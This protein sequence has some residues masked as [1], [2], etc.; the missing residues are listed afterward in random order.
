MKFNYFLLL[1]ICLIHSLQVCVFAQA[2]STVNDVL[3]P[4]YQIENVVITATRTPRPL[5]DIPTETNVL[6]EKDLKNS[7]A[8]TVADAIRWIPG[9]SIS[10][11]AAYGSSRRFT[12]LIRG[13][14][15]HYSLVLVDGERVKGEHIHTGINLNLIPVSMVEQIEVIKGPS[16]SLYGSEAMGGIINIISKPI[17]SELFLETEY[18]YSSFNTHNANLSFGHKPGKAGYL[19]SSRM[20]S[21]DGFQGNWYNQSNFLGKFQY[22]INPKNALNINLKHYNINY[23]KGSNVNDNETD[24]I[25]S[26]KTVLPQ[27]SYLKTTLAYSQFNGSR[28]DATNITS[29]FNVQYVL[30][31]N[32]QHQITAGGECRSEDFRRVATPHENETIFNLFIQDE[33]EL[34]RIISSVISVRTDFHENIQPVISPG[35]SVMFK[36]LLSMRIRASVSRG[37]RAPSLQDKYEY[38]FFHKTYYRDGNPELKPEYSTSYSCGVEQDLTPDISCRVSLFQNKFK[39]LIAVVPTGVYEDTLEIHRKE[40]INSA[41]SNGLEFEI[42]YRSGNFYAGTGYSFI[43][44]EDNQESALSYNPAHTIHFR[45]HYFAEQIQLTTML[46]VENARE[47]KYKDKQGHE[48]NLGDYTLVNLNITKQLFKKTEAFFSIGNILDNKFESY[49]EGKAISG[50]GRTYKVGV[51]VKII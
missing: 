45:C 30:P 34:T 5:K 50:I 12:A 21:T 35:A 8:Q 43:Q 11:G 28:K 20:S 42:K 14:P 9:I 10:G 33:W 3:P 7:G 26:W 24:I 22:D 27:K 29:N 25:T 37:F 17:P 40:N 6:N 32:H 36:P 1:H 16:S 2:D 41:Q 23:L 18:A 4:T 31:I 38:H 19:L 13:L 39:D 48:Q 44:A 51:R 49:E 15:S 46:S 47:R